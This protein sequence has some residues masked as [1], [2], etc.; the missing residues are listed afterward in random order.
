MPKIITLF[1]EY[2]QSIWLDYIDRNLVENGGLKALIEE[3]VRGVTSN[4][5]IFH[6]AI[7]GGNDYDDAIRDLLQADHEIDDETLYQWLAIQD[8]QMAADTLRPVYE[9]SKGSDGFVSL[10]VSPHIAYEVDQ[11][12]DAARHLWRAVDRPNLMIKVPGTSPGLRAFEQLI[13]EGINVNVTLLFSVDRYREVTAAYIRGLSKN[14]HPGKVAS[15][16][17]FFVSRVDSKVDAALDATGKKDA[18]LLKG[19]IAIANAKLA[20]QHHLKVTASTNFETERQRGAKTQRP[21]WASTSTKNPDY[22]DVLYIDQLI[23]NDTVNTVT[24]D[25]LE[26]F[27]LHGDLR[28]TVEMDIDVAQRHLKALT[29]FGVD[30]NQIT[31]ELEKEGVQKFADSYD[32][33]LAALK[34]KRSDVAKEYASG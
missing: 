12:I 5:T 9:N 19:K 8:I 3:G 2:G 14:P 33:L 13:A 7:T 10:E 31:D 21:L 30:L 11:T 22:S 16:A 29:V 32:Q 34:E 27:Q 26:A 20:Y 24:P 4:P 17:S 23:G 18:Q 6:K 25:T 28:N 15:V 1:S